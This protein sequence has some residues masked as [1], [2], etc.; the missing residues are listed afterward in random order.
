MRGEL[1]EGLERWSRT[2]QANPECNSSL[3]CVYHDQTSR[4]DE[5]RLRKDPIPASVPVW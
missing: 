4:V 5:I 1:I 2:L 3:K